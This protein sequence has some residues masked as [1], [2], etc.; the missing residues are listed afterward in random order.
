M[1]RYGNLFE[2]AFTLDALYQ[3]YLDARKSK[4]NKRACFNF[5]RQLSFNLNSLHE[6][7]HSGCYKPMPYYQFTIYEPKERIIYAPAFRDCVVQHAIYRV[8]YP[9]FD[10]TFIHDSYACRKGKGTHQAAD[11]A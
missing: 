2:E 5:E 4:R 9:L 7:L 8:I 10:R 1:K 6:E 3:G 11:Y